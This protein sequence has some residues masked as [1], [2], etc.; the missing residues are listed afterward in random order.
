[1]PVKFIS[2]RKIFCH[3]QEREINRCKLKNSYSTV[4]CINENYSCTE[5][6]ELQMLFLMTSSVVLG[7][8]E[9]QEKI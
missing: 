1:M 4:Y 6:R 7:A 2:L 5:T 9:M 3:Y 8:E